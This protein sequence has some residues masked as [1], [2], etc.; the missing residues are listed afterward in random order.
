MD[1][2][3]SKRMPLVWC[4]NLREMYA[5][6]EYRVDGVW[7]RKSQG[8]LFPI[9][10]TPLLKGITRRFPRK[11]LHAEFSP[12]GFRHRNTGL[13]LYHLKMIDPARRRMRRDLYAALDPRI[14]IG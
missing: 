7:G 4:F 13:N 1:E 12:R 8:R 5:A 3:T 14:R 11:S 2:L 6:D 10:R 9:Y